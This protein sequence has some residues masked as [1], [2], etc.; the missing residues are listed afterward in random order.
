MHVISTSRLKSYFQLYPNAE[1][2][3][4]TWLKLTTQ[5]NWK[6]L[7]EVRKTFPTADLVGNLTV[8]N[9]AGNHYRLI[10]YIDYQNKKV[11][12]R[13]FLTHSQYDKNKW[14]QDPWF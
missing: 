7:I 11:F 10:T 13:E 1:A 3:L 6:N 12:I 5:A 14:K 4:R 2:A 8:F 9:I